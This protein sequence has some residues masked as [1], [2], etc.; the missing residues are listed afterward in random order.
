MSSLALEICEFHQNYTTETGRLFFRRRT[1]QLPLAT[2]VIV[3]GHVSKEMLAPKA[4]ARDNIPSR[5]R[6]R[7]LT[8]EASGKIT[9]A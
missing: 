2:K 4:N 3:F 1:Q 5:M 7:V 8:F 6:S 9:W